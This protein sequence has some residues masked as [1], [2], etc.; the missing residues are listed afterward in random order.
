MSMVESDY[1]RTTRAK[2]KFKN[3][4]STTEAEREKALANF[5][6]SGGEIQ[7]LTV[8]GERNEVHTLTARGHRDPSKHKNF[9]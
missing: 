4:K 8:S 7:R 3:K 9:K 2:A 1:L 5:L 6:I